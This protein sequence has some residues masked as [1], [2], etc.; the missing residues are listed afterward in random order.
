MFGSVDQNRATGVDGRDQ[1]SRGCLI[2]GDDWTDVVGVESVAA[3]GVGPIGVE[4]EIGR[5]G[6]QMV[7]DGA[8]GRRRRPRDRVRGPGR[9]CATVARSRR[10]G[11]I[12]RAGEPSGVRRESRT[13]R[14]RACRRE[15]R[16]GGRT[17]PR[18]ASGGLPSAGPCRRLG[19]GTRG[20]RGAWKS[21]QSC[22]RSAACRRCRRCGHPRG[23][24]GRR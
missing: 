13:G 23:P 6:E 21:R 20:Q 9:G 14:R 1:R 8:P 19:G 2:A 22:L 17:R 3:E 15:W 18:R 24:G 12:R 4:G 11:A 5:G 16:P 10:R 7:Q